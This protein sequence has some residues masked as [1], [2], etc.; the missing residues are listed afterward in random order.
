M[1]SLPGLMLAC[2]GDP[3][4][5]RVCVRYL[6]GMPHSS[7]LRLGKAGEPIV[8][9]AELEV[10]PG[11]LVRVAVQAG[12]RNALITTGATLK[13][14]ADA[15]GQ[16]T[17]PDAWD[18]LSLPLWNHDSARESLINCIAQ[19]GRVLAVEDHLRTGGS[20]SFVCE[21][22]KETSGACGAGA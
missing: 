13:L 3:A 15:A 6:A 8:H 7:Y 11:R 1:R 17:V 16:S 21:C 12:A 18:V 10:L 22:L 9:A 20:A 19:C 4:G 5:T 14:A 2:P